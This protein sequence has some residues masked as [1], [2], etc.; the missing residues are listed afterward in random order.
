MNDVGNRLVGNP[1][2]LLGE[3]QVDHG[4]ADQVVEKA[5]F[6]LATDIGRQFA[7][8]RILLQLILVG[9]F[10][11]RGRYIDTVYLGCVTGSGEIVVNAEKYEW[12]TNDCQDSNGKCTGESLSNGLQ[13]QLWSVV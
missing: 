8:L 10:Q 12:H 5:G 13:H 7:I 6:Q 1:I 3:V 2:S 4:V 11:L 9:H